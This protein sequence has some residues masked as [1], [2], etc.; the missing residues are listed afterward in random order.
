MSRPAEVKNTR[1]HNAGASKPKEKKLVAPGQK[2]LSFGSSTATDAPPA[3]LR[4]VPP[5]PNKKTEEE[6]LKEKQARQKIELIR[7]KKV[8]EHPSNRSGS[9]V[10]SEGCTYDSVVVDGDSYFEDD[11]YVQ[12]YMETNPDGGAAGD[13]SHK[14]INKIFI[15]PHARTFHCIIVHTHEQKGGSCTESIHY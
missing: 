10:I 2:T 12:A 3:P 7:L 14:I 8:L 5:T 4:H 6:R 13:N 9:A 11:P 15:C 1:G